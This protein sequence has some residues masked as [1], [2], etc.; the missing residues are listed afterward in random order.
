MLGTTVGND[1]DFQEWFLPYIAAIGNEINM[2]FGRINLLISFE[3][4]E[5]PY[6]RFPNGRARLSL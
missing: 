5:S 6:N 4:V 3:V 2:R 1:A